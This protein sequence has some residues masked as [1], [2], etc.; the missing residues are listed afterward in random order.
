MPNDPVDPLAMLIDQRIAVAQ[1]EPAV[2]TVPEFC[3]RHRISISTYH[4]LK[5]EGRGPRVM[6]PGA[7]ARITREAAADWRK[8]MEAEA[9]SEAAKLEHARR[10]MAAKKGAEK[11]KQSPNHVCRK[12][13][14]KQAP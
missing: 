10:V 9:T 1:L 5:K 8:K 6:Q 7:Q 13:K 11:S 2:C 4:K 14:K 12:P 3:K